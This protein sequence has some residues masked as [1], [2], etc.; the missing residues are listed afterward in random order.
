MTLEKRILAFSKLGDFLA[1]FLNTNQA[2]SNRYNTL[3]NDLA[4]AMTLAYQTNNWFTKNQVTFNL[5]N[6]SKLLNISSLNHF[7]STYNINENIN[8]TIGLIPAGNIPLVGFHDLLCIL[9]S[10]N[11]AQI[12]ASSKD[13]IL[14]KFMVNA[15]IEIEP[16]FKSKITFTERLSDFDAIIATGSENTARYFDYYFS[17]Y[18]SIIR[19]NRTSVAILTGNESKDELTG[20]SQDIFRYYGLGCRNVTKVFLPKGY[21]LDLLFNAFYEHKDI[22]NHHRYANN[23]DYNKAVFLMNGDRIIENGFLILREENTSLF[24]PISSLSYEYYNEEKSLKEKLVHKKEEIQCIVQSKKSENAIPFGTTQS[25][26]LNDY[27]DDVDTLD[28]LTQKT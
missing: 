23:Y 15:L 26:S 5:E 18:P 17:K 14:T 3:H 19:K 24:S 6:W 25:L 8:K 2:I 13:N 1:E 27:A 20:L 11:E 12:K 7:L 21:D 10:G 28:F 22:I 16:E 4:S 9:I